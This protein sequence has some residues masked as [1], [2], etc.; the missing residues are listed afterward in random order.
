[1]IGRFVYIVPLPRRIRID[2]HL[3][4]KFLVSNAII[5]RVIRL[6]TDTATPTVT[7]T[8]YHRYRARGVSGR[9][10]DV[11]SQNPIY[12]ITSIIRNG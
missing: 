12:D 6:Q 7:E 2:F 3:Q 10:L 5:L 1:V 8:L 9:I 11:K 4:M